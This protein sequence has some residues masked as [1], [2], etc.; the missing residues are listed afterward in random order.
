MCFGYWD[1]KKEIHHDYRL[2]A[3]KYFT[4]IFEKNWKTDCCGKKTQF[5]CGKTFYGTWLEMENRAE[6]CVCVWK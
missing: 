5:P 3:W 1:V 4:F 2:N 6:E